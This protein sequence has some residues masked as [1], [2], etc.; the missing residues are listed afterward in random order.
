MSCFNKPITEEE[1]QAFFKMLEDE[2]VDKEQSY[3]S[4]W[5]AETQ[6]LEMIYGREPKL[7]GE[8][9]DL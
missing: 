3:L 8:D 5:N 7:Y 2:K 4:S 1:K 6:K 9:E